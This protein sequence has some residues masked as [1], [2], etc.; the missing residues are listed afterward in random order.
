[1]STQTTNTLPST[2]PQYIHLP[3]QQTQIAI[4]CLAKKLA[5]HQDENGENISLGNH[6]SAQ[7]HP[8][9]PYLIH[10]SVL[11]FLIRDMLSYEWVRHQT[12]FQESPLPTRIRQTPTVDQTIALLKSIE[13]TEGLATKISPLQDKALNAEAL[14][15]FRNHVV[16]WGIPANSTDG[17]GNLLQDAPFPLPVLDYME[18]SQSAIQTWDTLQSWW[19]QYNN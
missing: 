7:G 18:L 5:K 14:R 12:A 10:A 8:L 3:W 9:L 15:L 19:A 1:M 2:L 16:Q 11:L 4:E 17:S 6:A 13:K